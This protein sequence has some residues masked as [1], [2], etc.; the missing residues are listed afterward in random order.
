MADANQEDLKR[1]DFAKIVEFFRGK[2]VT[3]D[4][5][6]AFCE[7]H[8]L[9]VVTAGQYEDYLFQYEHDERAAKA[10]PEIMAALA[11]YRVAPELMD[12][13][14]RKKI[15]EANDEIAAEIC[16]ILERHGVV[17]REVDLLTKHIGSALMAI[18]ESANTRASNMCT[19][20]MVDLSTEKFGKTL[21]LKAFGEA[22]R[23]KRGIKE[24]DKPLPAAPE[25]AS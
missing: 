20:V 12:D 7:R 17:Y 16:V 21:P 25:V 22:F 23:A 19:S 24:E 6:K 8:K 4:V 1:G 14:A 2:P 18:M 11:T 10:F 5:L 15:I 13:E 3:N 9:P